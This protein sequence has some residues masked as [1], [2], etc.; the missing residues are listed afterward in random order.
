MGRLHN[1]NKKNP[2][3]GGF[4]DYFDSYNR[5]TEKEIIF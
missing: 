4:S 3:N 2:L 1:N 5:L